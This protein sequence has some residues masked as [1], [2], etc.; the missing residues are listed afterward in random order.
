MEEQIAT[1][2]DLRRIALGLP[3]TTEAPHFE[4]S[5]FKVKRI[6]V[7][8]AK[9]E[10]SANFNFTPDEQALK[11]AVASDAFA[12]VPNRWGAQGWTVARLDL[13]SEPELRD[14]LEMAWRHALPKR[15]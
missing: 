5:A 12:P 10:M 1:G 8:L 6:Y 14:A 15:P 11:C 13:L 7:T 9:D 3:G 2:Q 4:R